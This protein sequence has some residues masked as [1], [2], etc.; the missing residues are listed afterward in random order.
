MREIEISF[1]GAR[2]AFQTE[3]F[4]FSGGEVQVKIPRFHG[5]YAGEITMLARLQSSDAIMQLALAKEI[6]DRLAPGSAKRLIAPYFPY[7]RQDR[8][9]GGAGYPEAFSLKVAARMINA[10]G[11]D[12][13]LTCDPHSD[14]TPALVD[15]VEVIPQHV[16]IDNHPKLN[17]VIRGGKTTIVAPDAGALKK[18]WD[19]AARVFGVPLA[20]AS[21]HRD[22]TTGKITGTTLADPSAVAGRHAVIVDDICDGGRTFIELA[23]ALRDAGAEKVS[24]YATHGIFSSGLPPI[25]AAIDEI[26]TTDSFLSDAHDGLPKANIYRIDYASL[27]QGS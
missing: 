3:T 15:R 13:V 2:D 8:V 22:P 17:A 5:R 11:F 23:K 4:A 10:M 7:A 1:P 18:A 20:V 25:Y 27:E 12:R 16:I 24:L 19:V 6:V 9:M 14:V 26:Y 21:K